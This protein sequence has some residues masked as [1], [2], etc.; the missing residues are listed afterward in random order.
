MWLGERQAAAG[1]G[2]VLSIGPRPA[3]PGPEL[4]GRPVACGAENKKVSG[5]AEKPYGGSCLC[6]YLSPDTNVWSWCFPP[7]MNLKEAY[8]RNSLDPMFLQ[9]DGGAAQKRQRLSPTK[10][11]PD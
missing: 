10:A 11:G 4:R 1:A 6:G 9:V 7:A 2:P 3:A 8:K 5:P